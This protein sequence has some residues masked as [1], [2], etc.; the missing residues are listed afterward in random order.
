M[1]SFKRLR[2]GEELSFWISHK[3][4]EIVVFRLMFIIDCKTAPSFDRSPK[5]VCARLAQLVR[6]L[7]ANHEVPGSIRGLVEG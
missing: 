4:M 3:I 6:A 1:S 2:K 5:I 7:T